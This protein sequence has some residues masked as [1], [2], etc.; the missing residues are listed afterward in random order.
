MSPKETKE[1]VAARFEIL[2]RKSVCTLYTT[3]ASLT[4]RTGPIQYRKVKYSSA[5]DA[6]IKG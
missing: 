6:T 3:D 1:S 5:A 2:E 4:D